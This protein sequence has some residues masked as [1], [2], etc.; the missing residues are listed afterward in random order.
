MLR[1]LLR[2]I[3]VRGATRSD[4]LARDLNVSPDL[5]RLALEE[6]VRR[7]YLRAVALGCSMACEPCPLRAA[8]LS[9]RQPRVWILTPEGEKLL[10]ESRPSDHTGAATGM[11]ATDVAAPGDKSG[12]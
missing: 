4:D 3:A 5:L 10:S 12:P 8:C 1:D 11:T 6:L 9:R 2:L 7:D